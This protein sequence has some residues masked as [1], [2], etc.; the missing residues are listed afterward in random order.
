M[1]GITKLN[2]KF[3]FSEN[4]FIPETVHGKVVTL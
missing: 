3:I 1:L 2:V 4:K